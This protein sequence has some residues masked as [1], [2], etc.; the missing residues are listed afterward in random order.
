MADHARIDLPL[1]TSTWD[2]DELDAL[3]DVIASDQFSMGPRVK[4]FEREFAAY[5][6]AP[7]AIM[8]NSGSSAN[9]A[10]VAAAV[11]NPEV[12]LNPGDEVIVPA[13]SWS[14]TYYPLQQYGLKL[15]F[16]DINKDTLNLDLDAVEAAITDRTRA[17]FAVNLLG[18][19][20]DFVALQAIADAHKLVILEDN[21]ESLGA[22]L[23]GKFAGSFGLM[24]T[25]SSFFSHH[26]STMEG[27]VVL[28]HDERTAH[29]LHSLRA[30]GWLRGL[31]ADS[32]LRPEGID[33]FTEL[34]RFVLPGYNLR[35]L[36]MSGALGS[37]QLRKVP[38]LIEGR[39]ANGVA[40][41]SLFADFG[42]ATVQKETG[43]SS[44]FGFAL[45]L[46]GALE[47]HRP[48]VVKALQEAGVE[49]RPIVAGNFTKNP[50]MKHLDA[51]ISGELTAADRVDTDG[52]FIGN[53]H[54]DVSAQLTQVRELMDR[55]ERQFA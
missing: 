28:A 51:T 42:A 55:L 45:T 24:G 30:H 10:A 5:F 31:P 25:F 48:E 11:L 2:Q 50:V 43:E 36:E 23:D 39:R 26:I 16:V 47:G 34:F 4:D 49:C 22:R 46:T 3:Q 17:V 1:A 19:P 33:S 37:A 29:T 52:F 32:P 27:G 7:Y 18:N 14:T 41:S 35:P 38:S 12:D 9:L 44:W 40:F 53:H 54:Y 8:V 13:V 15:R 6:G 20:V 21:C